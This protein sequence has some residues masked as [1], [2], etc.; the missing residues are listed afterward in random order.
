[1]SFTDLIKGGNGT[2]NQFSRTEHPIRYFRQF[3]PVVRSFSVC[4]A[5]AQERGRTDGH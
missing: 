1:M 2:R 5:R 4:T 3:L